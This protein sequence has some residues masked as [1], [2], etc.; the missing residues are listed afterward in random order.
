MGFGC[1]HGGWKHSLLISVM[2]SI[3]QN[4]PDRRGD[5]VFHKIV[6]FFFFI[7]SPIVAVADP[8]DGWTDPDDSSEDLD[9]ESETDEEK[10]A[11]E[12]A[13]KNRLGEDDSLDLLDDEDALDMIEEEPTEENTGDLL[14]QE[15]GKDV[16]GGEGEDN[17]T[18]YRQAQTTNGRMIPDE[19]MIAWEQYLEQYPNSLYKSRIE[20]R[21]EELEAVL[22]DQLIEQREPERLDADQRELLF[23][24]GLNLETLNPRTRAQF[25]FEWGL[26]DYM[27]L[28]GDYE[29]QLRRDLSVH[30]GFRRRY[31]GWNFET[32]VRWALIKSS[33][34]KT[35]L[36]LMYDF[37]F[38]MNPFFVGMRPQI[39]FGKKFG[40]LDFQVQLGADFE[41]QKYASPR[42]LSGINFTYHAADQVSVFG[43]TT[44]HM[45]NFG[46][47]DFE[48]F[49][50]NLMS[51]GMKFYPDFKGMDKRAMEINV[52][53]SIPYT[54]AYWMYHFGAISAQV[55]YYL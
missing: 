22:Y 42:L 19:E 10:K 3:I 49:R 30:A 25:A 45:R 43:E 35:L 26:P 11:A 37:H 18:L 41:V 55:N 12:E 14:E 52:G 23:A 15:I 2:R 28:V 53:A 31:T 16:I 40:K 20:K 27:S 21:M 5:P 17:S 47:P 6:L 51:F 44:L 8:S 36:V 48:T 39:G 54:S 7:M 34:T 32:G 4:R 24:Q 38:N 33:R 50:F 13:E 9:L 29:H 1:A 46:N